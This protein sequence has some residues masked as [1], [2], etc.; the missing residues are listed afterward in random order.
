MDDIYQNRISY[1]HD[2]SNTL[3][4]RFSFTVSDGTNPFFIV[5]EGGKEVRTGIYY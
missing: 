2:G 4:D 5:E 1:N 3:K